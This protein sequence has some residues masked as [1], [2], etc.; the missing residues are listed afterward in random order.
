MDK[1]Q[2]KLLLVAVSVG[3]FLL[4]TIT[5]AIIILT[6]K[7]STEETAFSSSHPVTS[8]R[9]QPAENANVPIPQL[10]ADNPQVTNNNTNRENP[11]PVASGRNDTDHTTIEIPRPT[12]AAVPDNPDVATPS[13]PRPVVTIAPARPAANPA[14]AANTAAAPPAE[15]KPASAANPAPAA[16]TA[17]PAVSRPAAATRQT[18][19]ARTTYDY[20]I[21]TGAYS[22]IVRAEDA[23][24]LLASK[25]LTSIIETRVIDGRNLYRVR[26][27]PYTSER[28]AS[29]WLS[30]VRAIDG[31][32]D[33]Q[34]RQTVRQQ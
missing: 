15:S 20:W 22:S 33:S 16:A 7:V 23:K 2:K 13:Q 30:L 29:Y 1:E 10:P 28:E 8:A 4:V 11:E 19:P 31:F 34:I 26:L 14:P 3:V 18:T 27:G 5:V 9:I 17:Q 12:T 24:E 25:G 21:Q 6:P 32:S